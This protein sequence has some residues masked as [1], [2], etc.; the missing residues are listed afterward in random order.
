MKISKDT[1]LEVKDYLTL[2]DVWEKTYNENRVYDLQPGMMLRF[3]CLEWTDGPYPDTEPEITF[4]ILN[5][6]HREDA[7]SGP[8]F[9]PENLVGLIKDG[10][11]VMLDK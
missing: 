1:V 2:N 7:K 4:R 8:G 11:I 6:R 9:M 3:D 10:L 5:P